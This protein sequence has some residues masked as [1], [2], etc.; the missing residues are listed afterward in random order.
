MRFGEIREI[1]DYHTECC[2]NCDEG[3]YQYCSHPD[4]D[5]YVARIMREEIMALL[6][7]EEVKT[8]SL[9]C[10]PCKLYFKGQV[11]KLPENA[12]DGDC[13]VTTLKQQDG[14]YCWEDYRTFYWYDN[15]WN[16]LKDPPKECRINHI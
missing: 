7:K 13:Y 12:Q 8:D 10:V 9:S 11:D 2:R 3:S 6:D 15:K 4:C 16:E 5:T 14:F 1:L